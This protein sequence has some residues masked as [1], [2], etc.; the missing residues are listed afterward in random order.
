[1]RTF[2]PRLIMTLGADGDDDDDLDSLYSTTR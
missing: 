2:G 1:M